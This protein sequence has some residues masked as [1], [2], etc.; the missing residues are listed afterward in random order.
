MTSLFTSQTSSRT[1]RNSAV[2]TQAS[3]G[4]TFTK[5]CRTEPTCTVTLSVNEPLAHCLMSK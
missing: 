4:F 1:A 2:E 3:V 5:L